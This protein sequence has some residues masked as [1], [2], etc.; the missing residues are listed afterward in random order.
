MTKKVIYIYII[1][2][3]CFTNLALGQ[4]GIGIIQPD[5]NSKLEFQGKDK[6]ILDFKSIEQNLIQVSGNNT[7]AEAIEYFNLGELFVEQNQPQLAKSYYLESLD[8]YKTSKISTITKSK[9]RDKRSAIS[10]KDQVIFNEFKAYKG[11]IKACLLAKEPQEALKY[12]TEAETDYE[13]R[14]DLKILKLDVLQDNKMWQELLH[15]CQDINQLEHSEKIDSILVNKETLAKAKLGLNKDLKWYNDN[16]SADKINTEI[17]SPLTLESESNQAFDI[18]EDLDDIT[19]GNNSIDIDLKDLSYETQDEIAN[20]YNQNQEFDKELNIRES[21]SKNKAINEKQKAKQ[22][23]EIGK[24]YSQKSKKQKA[25]SALEESLELA[26]ESNDVQVQKETLLKLI[27]VYD[28]NK[29][30]KR[31][32]QFYKALNVLMVLEDSL[33]QEEYNKLLDEF[34]QTYDKKVAIDNI[35][36]KRELY[37]QEKTLEDKRSDLSASQVKF[38][39]TLIFCLILGLLIAAGV[40]FWYHKQRQK[41]KMV[42][43]QLELK[44][45]RNQMNPHFIFNSLNAVNHFIAQRNELLANEYLTEFALLMRNTLNQSDLD[46][47]PL[48]DELAF[49]N[50]YC[51]LEKMR[52]ESKFDF[53]FTVDPSIDIDAFQIPPL[54]LQPFVENAVWHG[55]RYLDTKGLLNISFTQEGNQLKIVISDNGIGREKS[56]AIKTSNQKKHKSKGVSL[57]KRRIHISNQLTPVYINWSIVDKHPQGTIVTLYLSKK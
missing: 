11:L 38:Q 29:D 3:C 45:M 57:I 42:N 8:I 24:L 15:L 22:K 16:N 41:L 44:N 35:Q 23:L 7:K 13:S 21:L 31:I 51:E 40:L 5:S 18:E 52:F 1:L 17:E 19:K 12:L 10:N 50:R 39:K 54:L 33:K 2:S 34:T 32:V 20:T 27:D 46:L 47:I 48:R 26:K 6:S 43:L 49:L 55:L 25:I 4:I 36:E 53:N 37:N 14:L 30:A 28:E 9:K 56:T